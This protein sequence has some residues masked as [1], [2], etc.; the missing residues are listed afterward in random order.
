MRL[1]KATTVN[2]ESITHSE[3]I[4][5][6]CLQATVGP[7]KLFKIPVQQSVCPPSPSPVLRERSM[8]LRPT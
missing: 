2:G 5:G 7:G 4:E 3:M 8:Y 1:G 6:V